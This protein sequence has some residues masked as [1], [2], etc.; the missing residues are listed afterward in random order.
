MTEDK[1]TLMKIWKSANYV[2]LYMKIICW[3]FHIK[4]PFT[5][6]LCVREICEEF[7]YKHSE[8]IKM[9]K[10]SLL[11]KKFFTFCKRTF[12][13]TPPVAASVLLVCREFPHV[14]IVLYLVHSCLLVSIQRYFSV[15]KIAT[16]SSFFRSINNRFKKLA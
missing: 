11:F 8:T 14:L 6:E 1:G 4:I 3:R 9:L 5:F 13:I 2:R 10:I 16:P 12:F 15:I 7:V